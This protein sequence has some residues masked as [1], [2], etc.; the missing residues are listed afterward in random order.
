MKLSNKSIECYTRDSEI[1]IVPQVSGGIMILVGEKK[2][3]RCGKGSYKNFSRILIPKR[4][5]KKILSSLQKKE[6]IKLTE[7]K[8]WK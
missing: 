1:Y 8:K 6:I 4:K 2:E 7:K 3:C 5:W